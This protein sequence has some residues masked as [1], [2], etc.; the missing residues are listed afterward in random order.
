VKII[1]RY[2]SNQIITTSLFAIV[3]LSVVLVLGNIFKQL[4]EL[5]IN[6]DAPMDLI[7]SVIA[8]ILPFSL[9]YTIPWGFLTTVMLVFGKMSAENELIA[10]RSSGISIPR[11][12]VPIFAI[13]LAFVGVCLYINLDVAPKAQQNM[14]EALYKLATHNP[15]SMFGSD[16][17]IDQFPGRKIYVERN[18]GA[19]LYNLLVYEMNETFEPMR[20][21]FAKHGMLQTDEENRR[22]L[23][24]IYDV[25]F[26]ERDENDSSNLAK[27]RQGI[28]MQETTTPISLEE[29]Y[30]KNK[31][32]RSFSSLTVEELIDRVNQ[33]N[34]EAETPQ[35]KAI[36]KS[37]ALTEVNR[38]FSFSIACL[39][40]TL[41]GVPLAITAHRKET[42]VGFAIALVVG[43]VY[44]FLITIADSAR[45]NPRAHPELLVWAP[46]ILFIAIG[47][48]LFY[49]LSRR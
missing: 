18:E 42:S 15:L 49:R 19:Q 4:A 3:V 29:L 31:K 8:Y 2:V 40:F 32:R 1:D 46:N 48:V 12:C 39:A 38:R 23:L 7:L 34:P 37:A 20:V 44:F 11:I 25:R 27:I 22:I 16:R 6:H 21:I 30:E 45:N 36:V 26:E 14:K 33:A 9:T 41:F 17:I 35:Q 13:A 43:F 10:L 28:T 47:L 24:H 5:L